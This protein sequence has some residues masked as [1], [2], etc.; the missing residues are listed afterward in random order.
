MRMYVHELAHGHTCETRWLSTHAAVVFMSN[1]CTCVSCMH[2]MMCECEFVHGNFLEVRPA[3][4][5][6]SLEFLNF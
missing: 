4:T 2:G 3:H 6:F 1:L 5:H